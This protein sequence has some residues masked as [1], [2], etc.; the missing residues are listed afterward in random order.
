MDNTKP[1]ATPKDFFLW[2]GAVVTLYASIG[3]LITLL[4]QYIDYAFPDPLQNYVDPFNTAISF[5]MASLIVL[6]PASVILFRLIRSDIARDP[7]RNEVWVRRWALVLTLFLAGAVVIGDLIALIN[8]FLNGD[9][10]TRFIL[11]V[12]VVLL[13]AGLAFFHFLADLRGY[14]NAHHAR[15]NMV[16]IAAGVLVL[17]AIVS[18]F[19]IIG[20]PSTQRLLR[21]DQQKVGDLQTIQWQVVNYWQ[22]KQKLPAVLTDLEDPISGFTVPTD[23]ETGAPY[24]YRVIGTTSFEL[25]ATFNKESLREKA[26]GSVPRPVSVYGVESENWQHGAGELC[27]ER[28]ID[29][30][31][32][33][34]ISK[35]R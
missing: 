18:G 22:Q 29:P 35:G 8:T 14:W 30:E 4:F 13:V 5:A 26:N 34:P 25:C 1:K 27:F 24:E 3:A 9:L 12:A 23:R 2:L 32:Y 11:K 19:L 20:S 16:G 33:P 15:A 6:V 10:T 31:R 17:A 21:A 28:T 7:S